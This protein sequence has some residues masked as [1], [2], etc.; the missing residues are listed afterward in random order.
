[1]RMRPPV[2]LTA[3]GLAAAHDKGITHRD[4]KPD[5]LFVTADGRVKILD[6]GLAKMRPL[7]SDGVPDSAIATREMDAVITDSGTGAGTIL[8]TVGYMAPEQV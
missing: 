6:F 2:T 3:A 5:N 4:L 1:M 8:G 7:T